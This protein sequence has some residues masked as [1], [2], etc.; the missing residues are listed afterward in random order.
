MAWYRECAL[1]AFAAL[2]PCTA[3]LARARTLWPAG[4]GSLPGSGSSLPSRRRLNPAGSTGAQG[5]Q[6]PQGPQG[7]NGSVGPRGARQPRA[8]AHASA[9]RR[10][11]LCLGTEG[12]GLAAY[13]RRSLALA[14]SETSRPLAC[15][16]YAGPTGPTGAA[17][18]RGAT[19]PTGP[20]GATGASPPPAAP[21]PLPAA[22]LPPAQRHHRPCIAAPTSL[23]CLPLALLTP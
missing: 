10:C 3:F 7:F 21:R 14:R 23:L 4:S 18:A 2:A 17:G 12:L 20:R 1:V 16:P 13:Q 5:L 19:G 9:R 6:G 11:L 15:F 22:A 8:A